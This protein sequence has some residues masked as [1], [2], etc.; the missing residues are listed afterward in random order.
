[1]IRNG[2]EYCFF[3]SVQV[4]DKIISFFYGMA[5]QKAGCTHT[6]MGVATCVATCNVWMFDVHKNENSIFLQC[7][8]YFKMTVHWHKSIGL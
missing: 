4:K 8:L 2:N 3:F 1:M 7:K 6:L 5:N